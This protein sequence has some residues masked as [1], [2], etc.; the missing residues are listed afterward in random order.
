MEDQSTANILAVKFPI[1]FLVDVSGS[2]DGESIQIINEAINI[3]RDW[4]CEKPEVYQSLDVSI[5]SFNHETHIIMP[6]MPVNNILSLDLS[7][8]GGSFIV[9]AIDLAVRLVKEQLQRYCVCGNTVA[10]PWIILISDGEGMD[11]TIAI[12]KVRQEINK[13]LFKMFALGVKGYNSHNL[14][15]LC[16]DRII[17]LNKSSVLVNLFD[18]PGLFQPRRT[19]CYEPAEKVDL[20]PS[21][22]CIDD[23]WL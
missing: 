18:W 2:M 10:T 15:Q 19:I 6:F 4:A 3:F 14:H 11:V 23:D 8:G 13:G 7:A 16:G 9:P 20:P 5:V 22:S 21:P 17:E 12:D 1:L